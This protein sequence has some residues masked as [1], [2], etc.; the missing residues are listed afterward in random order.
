MNFQGVCS[1]V[2]R[3][4]HELSLMIAVCPCLCIISCRCSSMF[5]VVSY[6]CRCC[7]LFIV[8]H[9]CSSM[10]IDFHC[11]VI[12]VH[13]VLLT[14]MVLPRTIKHSRRMIWFALCAHACFLLTPQRLLTHLMSEVSF[15]KVRFTYSTYGLSCSHGF[16]TCWMSRVSFY[17][18]F[19][20]YL[21]PGVW[22]CTCIWDW[23]CIW[24]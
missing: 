17:V 19:W 8:F 12:H 11:V 1:S 4:V 24:S 18:M 10:L 9:W 20:T 16:S 21:V 14:F 3:G 15:H 22:I 13:R 2:G 7:L 5:I 6:L 23:I